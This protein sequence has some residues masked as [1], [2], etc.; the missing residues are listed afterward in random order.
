MTPEP[1][2]NV[3][4]N[5]QH[6]PSLP[7]LATLRIKGFIYANTL[8]EINT[9]FQTLIAAQ[10]KKIVLDLAETNYVS[11]GGWGLFV[12]TAQRLRETG[13]DILLA[14][15]KPEIYDAFELLE[16]HKLIQLFP[17]VEAAL[18]EGFGGTSATAPITAKAES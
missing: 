4:I 15:M 8:P 2:E 5:I 14:S 17:T 12:N 11:T 7:E 13:G 1:M 3:S 10:R 16:F 6:H 18:Q 9:S